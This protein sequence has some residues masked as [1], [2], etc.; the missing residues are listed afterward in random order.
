MDGLPGSP[1]LGLYSQLWMVI[2]MHRDEVL[3][4]H[5]PEPEMHPT[6][7]SSTRHK[8]QVRTSGTGAGK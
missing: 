2:T 8:W 1:F 4:V 7:G 5:F 6:V 3:M